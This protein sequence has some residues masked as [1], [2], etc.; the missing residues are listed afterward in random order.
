MI[1]VRL[2][3]TRLGMS[4]D[5]SRAI[6]LSSSLNVVSYCDLRPRKTNG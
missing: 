4:L 3:Y 6:T 5:K 1:E 2:D